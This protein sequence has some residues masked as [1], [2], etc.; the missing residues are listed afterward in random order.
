MP[1]LSGVP[2]ACAALVADVPPVDVP[3]VDEPAL[4]DPALDV[5]LVVPEPVFELELHAASNPAAKRTAPNFHFVV[6]RCFNMV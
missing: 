2:V 5:V 3:P 6:L 1:I 4:D